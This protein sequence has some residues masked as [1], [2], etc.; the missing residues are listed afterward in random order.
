MALCSNEVAST[1][2]KSHR[3]QLHLF[4]N[5]RYG[6]IHEVSCVPKFPVC[7]YYT[8]FPIRTLHQISP[9]DL[10]RKHSCLSE[11]RLSSEKIKYSHY[12]YGYSCQIE[13]K[14]IIDDSCPLECSMSTY[15]RLLMH[16]IS[17]HSFIRPLV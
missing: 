12:Q 2:G 15:K 16:N 4:G 11:Y 5:E 10:S 8:K 13:C 14:F 3:K 7:S 9:F 17:L 6:C 1:K